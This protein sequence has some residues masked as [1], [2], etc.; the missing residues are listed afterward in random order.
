[1]SLLSHRL[2]KECAKAVDK[3]SC[4]L[5]W[6]DLYASQ[7]ILDNFTT[8]EQTISDEFVA[9]TVL[10]SFVSSRGQTYLDLNELPLDVL[11]SY[12]FDDIAVTQ[13]V[14]NVCNL[15]L[16]RYIKTDATVEFPLGNEAYQNGKNIAQPL[17][18]W[19][20]RLYLARYWRLQHILEQWLFDQARTS[21]TLNDSHKH[22][23]QRQLKNVF[24]LS[25]ENNL[26]S[27]IDWQA[28]AAAHTLL[29]NFCIITGGPG[30]GK[31]TTA[32]SI[33]F[34]L[35]QRHT[36]QIKEGVVSC[37]R[38]SVRLLA[39]TGKAAVKLADSIRHQIVTIENRL[40]G[41]DLKSVRM[42][43]CL[44]E[45]GETIH[46]FLYE[47]GALR[48]SLNQHK[49]F[50]SAEVLLGKQE[51]QKAQ[52][53]IIM[54][55]EASM[56]DLA[57]MV[58]LIKVISQ[59]TQ[60]IL[61]GDHHQLPAVEPGQVFASMVERYASKAYPS[62]FAN[63]LSTL[64][65]FSVNELTQGSLIS[66]VGM[67]MNKST[68]TGQASTCSAPI[69]LINQFHPLCQLRKTY[70]FSGDLKAAAEQ[71]KTGDFKAFKQQFSNSETAVRWQA[72]KG[73]ETHLLTI[74]SAY[75][76]Y[77]ELRRNGGTL[78]ALSKE[79][80]LFQLLCSTHEGPVGVKRMNELIENHYVY[81][82][83]AQRKNASGLYHGKAILVTRNHPHLGIYNGDIGFV[84]SQQ[85]DSADL[86]I[87]FPVKNQQAIIVAPGRLREWQP[88][89]AM[90]VHKSQ[91]SEYQQV[92]VVLADY[93]QELL[94]RALLYTALTR[95][96]ERCDIWSN[97]AALE[98]AFETL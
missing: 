80:E 48:E 71:I 79:F 46:R 19:N 24:S 95:S 2:L 68:N 98:R 26:S 91:G 50:S 63:S 57:L 34:L 16:V 14:Q 65:S 88:A 92:G 61:L 83:S 17:I 25:D 12:C 70:R 42:S 74:I 59:G 32:A 45:T 89:Y 94:S 78:A 49:A 53:D 90:T 1:M 81:Q 67:P 10:C 3:K 9:L 54:I 44:P 55:D 5:R 76:P 52:I 23:L 7:Y 41:A 56:I 66:A 93:A 20:Q 31:T 29:Q 13:R 27:D 38:L 21:Q 69:N 37:K 58:E 47:C 60:V 85:T 62:E 77:F 22:A 75:Q 11:P 73:E 43:D 35:M 6:I 84:I 15:P 72:L 86:A 28:V 51:S 82:E 36:L 4:A 97:S 40:L 64:T 96:K 33:L 8:A 39:P 18:Q 30:T 87:H